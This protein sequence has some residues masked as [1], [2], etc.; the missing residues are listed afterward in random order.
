ME[1]Q[2][3]MLTRE[4]NGI[5]MYRDREITIGEN[6]FDSR[7]NNRRIIDN[8]KGFLIMIQKHLIFSIP[9]NTY[10][11]EISIPDDEKNR[12]QS[13]NT[14]EG[15]KIVNVVIIGEKFK[16]SDPVTIYRFGFIN[17]QYCLVHYAINKDDIELLKFL[18]A[19]FSVNWSDYDVNTDI[20]T[21]L[22]KPTI[23]WIIEQQRI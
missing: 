12:M 23:D 7:C 1:P 14:I 2:Y 6:V 18:N 9:Q 20:C 4:E 10:I 15:Y 21:H 5:E 16:I 22:C 8:E 11:R 3:Y 17:Y 13:I 19:I